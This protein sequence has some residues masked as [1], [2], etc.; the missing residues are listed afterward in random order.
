MGQPKKR[1]RWKISDDRWQRTAAIYYFLTTPASA[2]KF[3]QINTD[4]ILYGWTLLVFP[5]PIFAEFRKIEKVYRY[6]AVDIG[7]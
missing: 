4:L 1:R 2:D 5:K 6:I 7:R 3:A